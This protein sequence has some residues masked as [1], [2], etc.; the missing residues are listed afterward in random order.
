MRVPQHQLLQLLDPAPG[1]IDVVSTTALAIDTFESDAVIVPILEKG[2]EE[3]G[4]VAGD[5]E[6]RGSPERRR[7]ASE[8]GHCSASARRVL[9]GYESERPSSAESL[10]EN[11]S[12]FLLVHDLEPH[13]PANPLKSAVDGTTLAT[14][15]GRDGH[16]RPRQV[17]SR[18]L[19]IPDVTRHDDGPR[20]TLEQMSLARVQPSRVV[21]AR[22]HPL[23][24]P[25]RRPRESGDF[26]SEV[27]VARPRRVAH[28]HGISIGEGVSDLALHDPAT[29]SQRPM[30]HERQTAAGAACGRLRERP[31]TG[32]EPPR[33]HIGKE[34]SGSSHRPSAAQGRIRAR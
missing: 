28:P 32:L 15:D 19:P 31:D 29:D 13:R 27:E 22:Q 4:Y 25:G 16:S 7:R 1:E 8:K 9:I 33:G 5:R 12:R 17:R 34:I 20:S 24:A 18:Q 26:F 6:A 21:G 14:D 11:A 2:T 23:D 30:R 10:N 3:E